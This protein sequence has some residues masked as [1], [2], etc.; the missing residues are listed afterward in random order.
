MAIVY[1]NFCCRSGGSNLNAGT[2]DGSTTEP[3][4]SALVTYPGGDWNSGT[5]VFTAAVGADM[6]EAVVDRFAAL[7]HDGDTS[8]TSNQYL[9]AR[10]TAVNAGA[11]TVT[12]SAT[13]RSLFG[14][15]VA[16]GTG[17]RSLSIG[18]AW[19]GPSGTSGFPLTF[20]GSA[21]TDATGNA[22]RLNIKNDQTYTMTAA[23]TANTGPAKFWM[24][25]STAYGDGGRA[26]ID[27]GTAGASYVLLTFGTTGQV[28]LRDLEIKNNGATGSADLI[29]VTALQFC[30][31]RCVFR[32]ARGE[33]IATSSG[34]SFVRCEF[35]GANQS[36]TASGCAVSLAASSTFVKCI[37]HD[38]TG[39]NTSGVRTTAG[40]YA[41]AFVDCIFDSNGE[42][43]LFTG[44]NSMSCTVVRCDFYSNGSDAIRNN[45]AHLWVD[46]C[47]FI[48]NTS[49]ALECG[50]VNAGHAIASKCGYGAGT[51][52][53]DAGNLSGNIDELDT[54]SYA[55]D[56]TPWNAPDTGDFSLEGE[57]A[58]STGDGTFLQT[59]SGYTGSTGFPD[60]GAVAAASGAG[61]GQGGKRAGASGGRAG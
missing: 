1:T 6:T 10:I 3:A 47:N 61:G 54:F 45:C 57:D 19:A 20:L 43:G 31:F 38:N 17:N 48:N 8:P 16:T 51:M 56:T 12:L 13:A 28:E 11:R 42:H 46:S 4:T 44:G 34:T 25:Y 18:G 23:I 53:N 22:P 29:S 35:Y 26:I 36:N 55:N 30:A 27:G 40:A 21:L 32:D 33:L 52:A 60:V 50:L 15:E 2:V 24:G 49:N 7:Y 39:S 37:F 14:T 59:A 58:I 5:D 9:V 41:V